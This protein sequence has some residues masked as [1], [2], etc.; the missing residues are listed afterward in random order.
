[1]GK[2]M[3]QGK[4]EITLADPAAKSV[5]SLELGGENL[6]IHPGSIPTMRGPCPCRGRRG[7]E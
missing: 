3:L 4:G 7:W 2:A 1:M 6:D 5:F